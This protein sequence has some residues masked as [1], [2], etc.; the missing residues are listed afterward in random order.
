MLYTV[1]KYSTQSETRPEKDLRTPKSYS[2]IINTEAHPPPQ[3]ER[4]RAPVDPHGTGCMQFIQYVK[5]QENQKPHFGLLVYIHNLQPC[6]GIVKR[7]KA[8]ITY[9]SDYINDTS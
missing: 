3:K 6:C 5:N 4:S 8:G 9:A 7:S 2:L 1:T